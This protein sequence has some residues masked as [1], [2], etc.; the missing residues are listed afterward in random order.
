MAKRIGRLSE[1]HKIEAFIEAT[2]KS[3]KDLRRLYSLKYRVCM[4]IVAFI[5]PGF[6][7]ITFEEDE[8]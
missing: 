7:K 1:S 6:L 3:R 4:R 2:E 5:L 8:K